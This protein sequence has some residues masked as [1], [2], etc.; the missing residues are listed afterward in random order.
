M[1]LSVIPLKKI[2]LLFAIILLPACSLVSVYKIDIPQ[3]TPLTKEQVTKVKVGMNAEQVKYILGSPATVDGLTPNQWDYVYYFHP[4]TYGKRANIPETYGEQKL[5][6]Y[7]DDNG[8]V[9]KIDG[10][11]TIPKK[12]YA[13]PTE[14]L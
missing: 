6:I 14:S 12:Q 13:T 7:F 8:V 9:T 11:E 5:S 2:S 3:G 10:L 4:G 1:K